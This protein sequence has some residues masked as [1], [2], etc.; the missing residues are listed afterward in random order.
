MRDLAISPVPPQ[1]EIFGS[2]C[3]I[4]LNLLNYLVNYLLQKESWLNET[5]TFF[6][7]HFD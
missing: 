6:G 4:Y 5:E 3:D 2:N 1:E 7:H